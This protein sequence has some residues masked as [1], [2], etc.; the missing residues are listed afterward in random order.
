MLN[1]GT[2]GETVFDYANV[3]TMNY[4]FRSC[5][6]FGK[7]IH[8]KKIKP[9]LITAGS[10]PNDWRV[11]STYGTRGVYYVVDSVI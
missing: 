10:S 6:K 7:P 1:L 4:M 5:M 3:I 11:S 9:L 8:L 2:V